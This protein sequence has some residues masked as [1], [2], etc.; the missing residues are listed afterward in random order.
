MLDSTG[1]SL[2]SDLVRSPQEP[3][4]YP[5]IEI[6]MTAMADLTRGSVRSIL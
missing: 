2:E 5:G 1:S 6:R 3:Y 4:P